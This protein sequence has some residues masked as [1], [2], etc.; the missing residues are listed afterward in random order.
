MALK[1]TVPVTITLIGDGVATVF[2][3]GVDRLSALGVSSSNHL[4]NLDLPPTS[5]SYDATNSSVPG[6]ASLDANSNLVITLN[7]ALANNVS[8]DITV[9]LFWNSGALAPN[10]R[11]PVVITVDR[12]AGTTTE[13]ALISLSIN[14]G[15]TVSTATNYAVTAGKTL[16]I[17][18]IA[19][20]NRINSASLS[21]TSGR[22]RLRSAA[23][24]AVASPVFANLEVS[25]KI[26]QLDS[27]GDTVLPIPDGMEFAG[28]QQIGF[29]HIIGSTS[30]TWSMC[31]I[32]YE[33]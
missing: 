14:K 20:S 33:Y 3:Y 2:T 17:Q 4:W 25:Q 28:G 29:T 27:I 32:G 13:A 1:Q 26:A 10:G 5:V 7:S 12:I 16:R 21:S 9:D 6:A 31:V 19:Y 22:L 30:T 18:S 23:T 8:A 11:V 24:V 15:G